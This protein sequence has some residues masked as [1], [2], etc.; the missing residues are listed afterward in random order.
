MTAITLERVD[1]E[2]RRLNARA[3]VAPPA[4]WLP[5]V[6]GGHEVG[7][8]HPQIAGLLCGSGNGFRLLDA[9]L[10]LDD[11]AL[12]GSGRCAR[13]ARAAAAL[14]DAGLLYG[15]RGEQV[16]IRPQPQSAVLAT[17]ERAACRAL[18]ITT[19]V[20]RLNAFLPNGDLVIAQR[21]AHKSIDPGLW[22]SLIGGMVSAGESEMQALAREARE[23]AGLSIAGVALNR[24]SRDG[25]ERGNVLA[26]WRDGSKVRDRTDPTRA[27]LKL[28]DER[29]GLLFVFRT[30]DRVSYALILSVQEPVKAGDRFTQP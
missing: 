22:D 4:A 24:G 3:A 26:L 11:E 8:T 18:G 14:R 29:H 6:I 27:E 16:D 23:E 20:V 28:P 25:L 1:A 9:R 17:I 7:I 21:A 30:F 13:L 10:V 2:C 12:D 5:V 15:W 19:L